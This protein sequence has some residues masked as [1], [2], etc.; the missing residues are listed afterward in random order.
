MCPSLHGKTLTL[1]YWQ[2]ISIRACIHGCTL[3]E[4][5]VNC[6]NLNVVLRSINQVTWNTKSSINKYIQVCILMLKMNKNNLYKN[7]EGVFVLFYFILFK[8]TTELSILRRNCINGQLNNRKIAIIAMLQI[9]LNTIC[10]N[11]AKAKSCGIK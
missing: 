6:R 9:Q 8:I 7:K 4:P 3:R 5:D 10:I 2:L 1:E 11:V